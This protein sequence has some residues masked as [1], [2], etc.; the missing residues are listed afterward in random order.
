MRAKIL[1]RVTKMDKLVYHPE[2]YNHE[3]RK[4]CWEEMY[5]NFG[6]EA[7][8]IFDCLNAYKY[9]YRAGTK[10]GNS[11]EQDINKARNYYNH[12]IEFHS[13]EPLSDKMVEFLAKIDKYLQVVT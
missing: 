12:A 11:K 7:V 8:L 9:L 6:L 4:E 5:E 13:A 1:G 10:E 3:G 2:H